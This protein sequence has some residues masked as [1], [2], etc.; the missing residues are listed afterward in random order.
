M[1]YTG[2]FVT[3]LVYQSPSTYFVLAHTPVLYGPITTQPQNV[4][5]TKRIITQTANLRKLGSASVSVISITCVVY[6]CVPLAI[7]TE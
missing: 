4:N 7:T 2:T 3:W 6:R 5:A 1:F